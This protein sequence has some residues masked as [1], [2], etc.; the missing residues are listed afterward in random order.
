[1]NLQ[2]AGRRSYPVVQVV[3]DPWVEPPVATN[4]KNCVEEKQGASRSA[5]GR[6]QEEGNNPIVILKLLAGMAG[7]EAESRHCLL[8]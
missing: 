7:E 5:Q 8:N 4:F 6:R 1:M 2:P 3:L